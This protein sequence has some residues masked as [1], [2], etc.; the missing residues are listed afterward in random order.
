MKEVRA[1]RPVAVA[2]GIALV[3]ASLAGCSASGRDDAQGSSRSTTTTASPSTTGRGGPTT[4]TRPDGPSATVD[5]VPDTVFTGQG[6]PRIDVETYDVSVKA[7]PGQPGIEG[8]V[9]LVLRP[10]TADPLRSFTLDLRGPEVTAA[11][12]AGKPAKVAAADAGEIRIT[13]AAALP[14]GRPARVVIRYAGTPKAE[15]FP[16]LGVPVGWQEDTAGSWF[17]M[18]EPNGTS[19]WVPVNDHPSDKAVWTVTL[20][21]PTDA[22]GVSN[23]RLLSSNEANGRRRWV[24]HTAQPMASYLVF[25][26]IGDFELVKGPGPAGVDVTYAFP[27]GMT[28]EQRKGFD[29]LPD[30]LA[31]F[32]KTFGPYPFDAAGAVVVRSTLG[33]AL[34]NQTRPLFG[35]DALGAGVV[36]A[37]PHELAHQWFGD[38]VSPARWQD[39]WLNESFATYADWLYKSARDGIP[40]EQVR[41]ENPVPQHTGLAVTDAEAA[42]TFDGT[43]YEGGATAL[44]ALRLEI[45]SEKF[46][47]LVRRWFHDYNGKSATTEDFEALAEEVSGRDLD[48]FFQTWLDSPDQPDLPD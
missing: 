18:S 16:S 46:F 25:A 2:V 45:G 1:R 28:A 15:A 8:R 35:T 44:H 36:W 7:D 42:A 21:T 34:E 31:F 27:P 13:P 29:E 23:G 24:W 22:T 6:D 5:D 9:E 4:T 30:I 26:A 10:T 40:V 20:D 47:E 43:I 32:S 19:T 11:S 14:P 37:L 33:L 48:S 12:V 41:K 17:T 39:V 38:A 3:V